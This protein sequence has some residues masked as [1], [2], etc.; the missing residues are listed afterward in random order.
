MNTSP[1]SP[2]SLSPEEG[3]KATNEPL[4]AT[5]H[6]P[7]YGISEPGMPEWIGAYRCHADMPALQNDL[8]AVTDDEGRWHRLQRVA[9]HTAEWY[10]ARVRSR[11]PR[12]AAIDSPR[13]LPQLEHEADTELPWERTPFPDAYDLDFYVF[14]EDQEPF[15][16]EAVRLVALGVAEALADLHAAGL[17]HGGLSPSTVL[18]TPDGPVVT[19][20]AFGAGE[21][22][23]AIGATDPRL[24]LEVSEDDPVTEATDVF[25]WGALVHYAATGSEPFGDTDLD[26]VRRRLQAGPLDLSG[27]P[28]ELVEP[29][30]LALDPD[31]ER[32]PSAAWLLEHL[33]GADGSSGL[34]PREVS[35]AAIAEY[36]PSFPSVFTPIDT[37]Q[38]NPWEKWKPL[39]Y[40]V[41]L[42]VTLLVIRF[43]GD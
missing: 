12:V 37:K 18:L 43:T 40:L 42:V 14:D 19:D 1:T 27:V 36:W 7:S 15:P 28:T 22:R 41:A 8:Y 32:R 26:E 16:V 25:A 29:V 20:A 34:D 17:V 4:Y 2:G 13:L 33:T 23:E 35:R 11:L 30:R 31:P 6:K 39:A 9:R 3:R 10:R 24:P 5:T 21:S 38:K